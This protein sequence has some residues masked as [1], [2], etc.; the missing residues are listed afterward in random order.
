[1]PY[2]HTD[3]KRA[4]NFGD[5]GTPDPPTFG[6]LVAQAATAS[7]EGDL[8]VVRVLWRYQLTMMIALDA[9]GT[10]P[11]VQPWWIA[12]C[13]ELTIIP[14]VNS[15]DHWQFGSYGSQN[16]SWPGGD[17]GNAM[18][19]TA[20]PSAEFPHGS[21]NVTWRWKGQS[22]GKRKFAG[23]VEVQVA[24]VLSWRSPCYTLTLPGTVFAAASW[25]KVLFG[26]TD[27]IT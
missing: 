18:P 16:W 5:W 24:P 25:I 13:P 2:A 6:G 14:R 7:S 12:V 3:W 15:E 22:R 26:S 23:P 19:I 11:V 9:D 1:M 4:Y 21:E 8:T 10:V 20:A 27:T 17:A